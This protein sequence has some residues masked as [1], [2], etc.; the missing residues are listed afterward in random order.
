MPPSEKLSEAVCAH[1]DM[2]L[3]KHENT[4]I[5]SSAYCEDFPIPFTDMREYAPNVTIR[6]TGD[7]HLPSYPHDAIF[8]ALVIGEKIFLKTDTASRSVIDYAE[9]RGLKIVHTNQGYPACTVLAFGNSGSIEHPVIFIEVPDVFHKFPVKTFR[10]AADDLPF[11]GDSTPEYTPQA[12]PAGK[13][14]INNRITVLQPGIHCSA[15]VTVDDPAI[16]FQGIFQSGIKFFSGDMLLILR[17]PK[18][19]Q[20]YHRQIQLFSQLSG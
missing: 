18:A 5:T 4:L 17:P 6:F 8:N 14:Q 15:V 9:K 13:I 2:L 19:I 1:P 7:E 10:I 11:P 3:F 20:M 16:Q 12:D